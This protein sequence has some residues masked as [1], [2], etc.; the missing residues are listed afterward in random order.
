MCSCSSFWVW[1]SGCGVRLGFDVRCILY[2][3]YY[4]ILL[5]IIYYTYT[6]IIILLLYIIIHI[7]IHIHILYYILYLILS[8]SLLSS[9]FPILSSVL[10]PLPPL[11]PLISS[12]LFSSSLPHLIY[13]LYNP[14]IQSIRVGSS[15]CLFIFQTHPRIIRPRM[16]YRSGWLRCV[17]RISIWFGFCAGER[18]AISRYMMF[19]LGLCLSGWKGKSVHFRNSGVLLIFLCFSVS[20]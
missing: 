2:Y 15:L 10:S 18:L 5:Y 17:V 6:I 8:S 11:P 19:G 13:S 7:R 16:F 9:S 12:V 14:L 3:Y 1:D 4:Y 20:E